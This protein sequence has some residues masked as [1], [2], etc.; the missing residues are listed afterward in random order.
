MLDLGQES[1][2]QVWPNT[3]AWT[4]AHPLLHSLEHKARLP[5]QR[6]K[7]GLHT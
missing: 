4:V 3:I 2:L 1:G 6:A 5:P 7:L